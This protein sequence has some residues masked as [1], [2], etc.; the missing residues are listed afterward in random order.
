M[1]AARRQAVDD[2]A[3][4]AATG[5]AGGATAGEVPPGLPGAQQPAEGEKARK[6]ARERAAGIRQW[7]RRVVRRAAF[8]LPAGWALSGATAR[9]PPHEPPRILCRARRRQ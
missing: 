6:R 7:R 1:H 2:E 4:K 9:S 5:Q 3:A 8:E